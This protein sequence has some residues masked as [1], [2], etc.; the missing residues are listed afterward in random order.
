[1]FRL[2]RAKLAK[3]ITFANE[4][5]AMTEEKEI[6]GLSVPFAA[7]TAVGALLL[8]AADCPF[9]LASVTAIALAFSLF[10]LCSTPRARVPVLAMSLLLCGIFCSLS[11]A[12][13]APFAQS[14]VLPNAANG[15]ASWLKN[16]IDCIPYS[17]SGSS[18]LVKALLTGDRS[19]LGKDVINVFRTAGASHILAL[20]GLHLG[21]IYAILLRLFFFLGNSPTACKIRCGLIIIV[22]GFY[23][24][25]T[26]GSP[27]IIRAFIFISL[28]ETARLLGRERR[29]LRIYCAALFIQLALNPASVSSV[30]F[31]LS[32]LAMAG[33]VLIFPKLCSWYPSAGDGDM[34]RKIWEAAALSISC[35]IFTAPLVWCVF[36]SFPK[37]F[38]ITNLLAMPLTSLVMLFSIATVALSALGICPS[39]LVL[40]DEKILNALLWTL[41]IISEM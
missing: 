15:A 35:Q 23:S 18:E 20:S 41:R 30:S 39:F 32:Y 27:S 8:Y 33:I 22:T 12:I 5:I 13:S 7:G 40:V 9:S 28:N 34:M 4:L 2:S 19:G 24:M 6:V 31:W 11:R 36:G 1:M 26:G 17:N 25:A 38:L 3:F 16:T 21:F 37:Y 29:P 10:H 14:G